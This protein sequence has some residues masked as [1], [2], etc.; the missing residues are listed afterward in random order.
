MTKPTIESIPVMSDLCEA[1]MQARQIMC[2]SRWPLLLVMATGCGIELLGLLMCLM[3]N[4]GAHILDFVVMFMGAVVVL[5]SLWGKRI[6][7]VGIG[8]HAP[9]AISPDGAGLG[10]RSRRNRLKTIACLAGG[11]IVGFVIPVVGFFGNQAWRLV[12]SYGVVAVYGVA[13]ALYVYAW[14]RNR[15]W[16][17]LFG[18]LLL[19]I[20]LSISRIYGL[21]IISISGAIVGLSVLTILSLVIGIS[22]LIRWRKWVRALPEGVKNGEE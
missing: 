17:Y 14:I 6:I 15:L 21:S 13:S 19:L 2:I 1:Q 11:V 12:V 7:R 22:F 20:V 5:L 9:L 10:S 8:N 3:M 16:E 4:R 18:A